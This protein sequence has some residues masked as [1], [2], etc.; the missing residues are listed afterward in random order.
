MFLSSVFSLHREPATIDEYVAVKQEQEP[1]Q[2]YR[3][4]PP[5]VTQRAQ[6]PQI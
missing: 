4:Q 2:Q 1:N 5:F 6:V 3:L